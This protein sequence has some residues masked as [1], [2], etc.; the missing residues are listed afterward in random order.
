MEFDSS[1]PQGKTSFRLPRSKRF[2]CYACAK[3]CRSTHP[4]YVFCCHPCGTRFQL[5]RHLSRDLSD[6]V[7][8]VV[9]ARTKLGHQIVIKLLQAGACVLGTTRYPQSAAALYQSYKDWPAWK[10]K[11][12]IYPECFDLDIPNIASAAGQLSQY[13]AAKFGKVDILIN[14]A[15]QTIRAREKAP[16]LGHASNR[17]GDAKYVDAGSTTNS[18]SMQLGDLI[19]QEMEEV[20]RI[21]AIGPCLVVQQLA[22]VMKKSSQ[23]PYVINVHAR[24]GLFEVNKGDCHLHTNMAKAGLAMLTKCLK[25]SHLRTD[26]GKPFYIHGCDPGWI[27]V[28]E[29]HEEGRP[30]NVP[31]L[32]EIDGAARILY[33]VMKQLKGS[34]AKT[35]RHFHTLTY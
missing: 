29:Y 4:T 8:V 35:R 18:W 34:F 23:H 5:N 32:D 1:T 17:Y 30:W 12:W 31:P 25:G 11:L 2:Q 22:E 20:Y 26:A 9:G 16:R 7:A 27:S 10:S 6:H 21:N 14:C 13:V 15:A 28:D 3:K 33:P 19:Q 24:E